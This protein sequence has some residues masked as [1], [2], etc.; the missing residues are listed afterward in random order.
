MGQCD[1]FYGFHGIVLEH[2]LPNDPD[3]LAK[4]RGELPCGMPAIF[5]FLSSFPAQ[6]PKNLLACPEYRVG[7][8]GRMPAW[9]AGPDLFPLQITDGEQQRMS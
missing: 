8:A 3:R 5:K 2:S 6:L 1:R 9:F 7:N 4:C